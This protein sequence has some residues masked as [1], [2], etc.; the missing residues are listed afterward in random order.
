MA[1]KTAAAT[2]AN[3]PG[4]WRRIVVWTAGVAVVLLVVGYFV[5]TSRTFLRRVILPRVSQAMHAEVT[6][7]DSS[8]SPFSEILLRN[9]KVRTTG[10]DPVLTADEVRAHYSLFAILRGHIKVSEL[11][12]V[13]PAIT[14]VEQP[15]GTKNT[16][17]L[18]QTD[19]TAPPPKTKPA[20]SKPLSVDI[21]K[22]TLNS[23]SF[24][25]VKHFAGGRETTEEISSVNL[26][27]DNIKNGEAGKLVLSADAR[28]NANPPPPATGS[29][30]QARVTANL[31]FAFSADFK[32]ASLKGN[33]RVEVSNAQGALADLA[34]AA[35]SLDADVTPGNVKQL[36]LRFQRGGASLGELAVSGPF[37]SEKTEG[38]LSVNIHGIDKQLLDLAGATSG[39]D[40]GQ[41]TVN[42]TNQVD[43]TRGG[44]TMAVVGR[45]GLANL[46][47]TRQNQRSPNLDLAAAYALTVDSTANSALIRELTLK[48]T[49][50]KRPLVDL[51]LTAPMTFAWGNQANAVGNS[52]LDLTLTNLNLSDWKALLGDAIPSGIAGARVK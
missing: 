7:G 17:P 5:A 32:P 8:V 35:V 2:S 46:Q 25:Y 11:V 4:K 42:S 15:D 26:E 44:A 6:V 24:R 28:L 27:I 43:I 19:K 10:T 52:A 14:V 50:D 31:D 36:A 23:L 1:R 45:T 22:V 33:A 47:F 48:G 40:F 12:L 41:A 16:D 29:I 13:G 37:D 18:F 21:G 3:R 38:H 30:V 51:G 49:Q 9:V 34:A 20:S 39:I